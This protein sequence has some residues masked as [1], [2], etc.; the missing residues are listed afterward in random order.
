M[1]Y[2]SAFLWSVLLIQTAAA[3]DWSEVKVRL[4]PDSSFA[5]VETDALG[6]K[7]R[8][9]PFR[10]A[11]GTVDMDQLIWVLG[12]LERHSWQ[13]PAR[14]QEARQILERH[15]QKAFRQLADSE[16][17]PIVDL[18]RA[19]ASQ[20]VRLP[21]IGPVLAVRII[22]RRT[23]QAPFETP[24]EIMQVEGIDRSKFAAIRHY[25]EIR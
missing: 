3:Q 9:C 2:L 10:E 7:H 22:E 5:V 18:N 12:T 20:L 24:Q 1:K 14:A 4:L 17:P 16:A 21:G 15:Y 25:I 11:D 8:H 23:S 13:D 6:R 19:T